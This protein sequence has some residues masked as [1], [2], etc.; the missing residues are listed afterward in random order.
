M[1]FNEIKNMSKAEFEQF[2]FKVQN[3]KQK[4][5]IR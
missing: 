2:I 1:N 5:C 3:S 4:F